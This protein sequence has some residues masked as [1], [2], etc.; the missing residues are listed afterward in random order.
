[1]SNPSKI[2]DPPYCQE[3]DQYQASVCTCDSCSLMSCHTWWVSWS[4]WESLTHTLVCVTFCSSHHRIKMMTGGR[5]SL[6]RADCRIGLLYCCYQ[7]LLTLSSCRLCYHCGSAVVLISVRIVKIELLVIITLPKL[8]FNTV[9]RT[10][11]LFLAMK[12]SYLYISIWLSWLSVTFVYCVC[13]VASYS[14]FG[15]RAGYRSLV[16]VDPVS[17]ISETGKCER[18]PV[19][20]DT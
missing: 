16:V 19:S 20:L 10:S 5:V 12:K 15:K 14:R 1:M 9:C 6:L 4:T 11:L 2:L 18:N 13:E 8:P 3:L 17:I 7:C